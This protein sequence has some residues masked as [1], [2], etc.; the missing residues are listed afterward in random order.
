MNVFLAFHD[1]DAL[2]ASNLLLWLKEINGYSG[3]EFYFVVDPD[4]DS[5]L[6]FCAKK[7]ANP[8][9]MFFLD[10][11]VKGW[12]AGSNALWLKAAEEAQKIGEPWLFLEPDAVPIRASWMVE[13]E[14]EYKRVGKDYMGALI[15]H[16]NSF[17]PNPYLE[18][19]SVYPANAFSEIGGMVTREKSWTLSTAGY[20]VPRGTNSKLFQHL[21]GEKDNPPT[22]ARHAM[23][24][25]NVFGLNY[26]QPQTVLFHRSKDGSLIRL[27]REKRGI[28]QQSPSIFVNPEAK[29][30]FPDGFILLGRNGDQ[31]IA[32]RGMRIIS[33]WTGKQ[34]HTICAKQFAQ[35]F[36]GASYVV[37]HPI[38]VDWWRGMPDARR[39][40]AGMGNYSVLQCYAHEWGIDINKWPSYMVS[41]WD[42]MGL[43]K[44]LLQSSKLVFDNRNAAREESLC[45]A[46]LSGKEKLV[47]WNCKGIS[48]PFKHV[49]LLRGVLSKLG[50]DAQVLDLGNVNGSRIYDLIGLYEK[51]A[52]ILTTDTATL[53]LGAAVNTP[54]IAFIVDGWTGSTPP[55]N[56]VLEMRYA[57]VPHR[58]REVE[59]AV[60]KCV[61]ATKSK[62]IH[63]FNT[64]PGMDGETVRRHEIAK[65][66]WRNQDWTDVEI[67]E[68]DLSRKWKEGARA[69]PYIKD[70]FDAAATGASD[71]DIIVFTNS[72]ICLRS[73]FVE[74][75]RT[76]LIVQDAC[77]ANRRDFQKLVSPLEDLM[78]GL[79][80]EYCGTDVFAFKTGWWRR[81]R[82]DFPDMLIGIEAWDPCLRVLM[83][84]TNPGKQLAMQCMAYHEKHG[85]TNHWESNRYKWT[86][87]KYALNTAYKWLSEH[88]QN[89]A[90][91]AIR[92]V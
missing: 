30:K 16:K 26:I 46:V 24:G 47:I 43:S 55:Q 42:R 6:V 68:Q 49:D 8:K 45:K 25:T 33:A 84:Q 78:I 92:K 88:G 28:R 18:G 51:A 40:G 27:L 61:Q 57:E 56:T 59:E 5:G 29:S 41:M 19:C 89:P 35:I 76:R 75:I 9:S 20:V 4:T 69:F 60:N 10:K 2:L 15:E 73:D 22:F 54:V 66:T 17:Q 50:P 34:Q 44:D 31:M 82:N 39:M 67:K 52:C 7:L 48:S 87:Q 37:P 86:A 36:D 65:L 80:P 14:S 70:I 72:D 11:P 12:I 3:C 85:G 83:C 90:N 32:L 21:W 81:V 58:M 91:F 13:I 74:Q 23:A 63:C 79:G 77:Y 71:D 64:W 53:H 1:G 38:D 62:V